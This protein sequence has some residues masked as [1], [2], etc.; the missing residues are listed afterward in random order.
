[1]DV[2]DLRSRRGQ[3]LVSVFDRPAGFPSDGSRALMSQVRAIDARSAGPIRLGFALPP[4]RYAVAVVHD[5]NRNGKLD[6]G[7]E[8]LGVSNNPKLRLGAAKF[9]AARFELTAQGTLVT[10]SIQYF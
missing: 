6:S 8:G 1:M 10:I 4:G 7:S 3:L 9:E 5:E 2:T